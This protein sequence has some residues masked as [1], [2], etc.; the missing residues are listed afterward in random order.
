MPGDVARHGRPEAGFRPAIHARAT[1]MK[2]T[3]VQ[4]S[5]EW[6]T[7]ACPRDGHFGTR[8]AVAWISSEGH[9]AMLVAL[10]HF[11]TAA[12]DAAGMGERR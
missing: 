4:E 7:G 1:R 8:A 11:D 12:A 10:D 9:F 5:R 6:P 2:A 3:R